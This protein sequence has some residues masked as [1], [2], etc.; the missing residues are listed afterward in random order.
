MAVSHINVFFFLNKKMYNVVPPGWKKVAI[1]MRWQYCRGGHKAGFHCN[2]NKERY[3][4]MDDNCY[5]NLLARINIPSY[6]KAAKEQANVWQQELYM[7]ICIYT[8]QARG[9]EG[10]ILAK[11]F[12]CILWTERTIRICCHI[13][14]MYIFFLYFN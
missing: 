2:K 13:S 12:F 6:P 7:Y 3:Q 4:S 9:Q 8:D 10:C 14:Y 1:I 5:T 11:F